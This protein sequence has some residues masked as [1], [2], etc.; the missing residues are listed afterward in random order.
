MDI[1]LSC[2]GW[3]HGAVPLQKPRP[4]H[5][6]GITR[7][8]AKFGPNRETDILLILFIV[9]LLDI[10]GTIYKI[11]YDNLMTIVR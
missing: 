1:L 4:G 10:W 3:W 5:A 7:P 9:L 11:S 6:D 8:H 2:L